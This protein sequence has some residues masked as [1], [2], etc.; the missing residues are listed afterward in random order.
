[1]SFDT[2]YPH[3]KDNRAPYHRRGR[4]DASCR[5]H[6]GCSYCECSRLHRHAR[7]APADQILSAS[8]YYAW[9]ERNMAE[10]WADLEDD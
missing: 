9:R 10:M 5:P 2:D 8:E 6:G 4:C 7:R 3:R 1:M